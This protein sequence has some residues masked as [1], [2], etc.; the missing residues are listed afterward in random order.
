[1]LAQSEYG[2]GKTCAFT[3][4]SVMR[5]DVTIKKPQVICIVDDRYLAAHIT[6]VYIKLTKFTDIKV[7]DLTET[8]KWEGYQIIVSCL[9]TLKNKCNARQP[10]DF[11]ELRVVVI[12]EVNFL[13]HDDD[14]KKQLEGLNRT[15]FSKLKQKIQ[16]I[17]F[18]ATYPDHVVEGVA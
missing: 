15:L 12:D 14:Y 11:S 2:S 8:G 1:M 6:E 5:V 7:S 18:S 4:G 3:I 17:L 10:I 9:G 13:F 16:W